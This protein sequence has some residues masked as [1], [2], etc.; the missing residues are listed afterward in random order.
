MTRRPLRALATDQGGLALIEFAITLPVLILL[1]FGAY[2]LLDASACKR[3]V[4]ITT[5]AVADITS[6]NETVTPAKLDAVLAASTQIMTPYDVNSATLR[7]S[8]ITV[9][10][11]F[12]PKV[13]W[14]QPLRTTALTPG[15]TFNAMPASMRVPGATYILAEVS[16]NYDRHLG[17]LIPALTFQQSLYMLPRKTFTVDCSTCS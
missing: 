9:D 6:Q 4:T 2:Q 15:S 14:S 7:V 10:S 12:R 3:R 16:Y 17:N 13:V 5:R 11:L 8:E 1:F